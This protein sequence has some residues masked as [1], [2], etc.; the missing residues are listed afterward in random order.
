MI[1]RAVLIIHA[2]ASWLREGLIE[3]GP[4]TLWQCKPHSPVLNL[5]VLNDLRANDKLW[6]VDCVAAWT[7]DNHLLRPCVG[8]A[9]VAS[10]KEIFQPGTQVQ[11]MRQK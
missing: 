9:K 1:H 6:T 7:K 2:V 4:S 10:V 5:S 8:R 3:K 11:K